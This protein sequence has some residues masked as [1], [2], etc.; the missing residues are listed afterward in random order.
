[1]VDDI[2]LY[3][4]VKG[5]A[6]YEPQLPNKK[7]SLC[8]EV[9]PFYQTQDQ[10]AI[11]LWRSYSGEPNSRISG[12]IV[13]EYP[14]SVIKHCAFQGPS[15]ASDSE[16]ESRDNSEKLTAAPPMM[17]NSTTGKTGYAV[18][19]MPTNIFKCFSDGLA[20]EIIN[21][22]VKIAGLKERVLLPL[23]STGGIYRDSQNRI[24]SEVKSLPR[25]PFAL[26]RHAG[27]GVV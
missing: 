6:S 19:E 27:T 25:N 11:I 17:P 21:A 3:G 13:A 16:N 1:L 12:A 24:R 2:S 8:Y 7:E 20:R 26:C 23:P 18:T 14:I 9:A 4:L 22:L 10:G 15:D 5:L